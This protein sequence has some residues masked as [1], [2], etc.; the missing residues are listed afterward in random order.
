LANVSSGFDEARK[1]AETYA[2]DQPKVSRLLGTA[3]QKAY[4]ERG[5]IGEIW[6]TLQTLLRL[7][8][9][10]AQGRYSVVP[11]PTLVFAVAGI[12]Y[13][14]DPLDLI[15]DPIPF[16]GYLDD[17]GILALLLKAI[18]KDVDRFLAWESAIQQG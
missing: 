10:W 4:R 13:F 16:L 2:A 17:A 11:W 14:V 8:A 6:E 9:A 12:L 18:R 15:P 5:R 3:A 1:Q 7:I